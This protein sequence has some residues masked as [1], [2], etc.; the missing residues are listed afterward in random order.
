M[1]DRPEHPWDNIP[2]M[3]DI[4]KDR[5]WFCG[6][7]HMPMT[8]M[9]ERALIHYGFKWPLDSA[10]YEAFEMMMYYN[11][12]LD[13]SRVRWFTDE[14]KAHDAYWDELAEREDQRNYYMSGVYYGE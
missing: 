10:S 2:D 5:F 13:D 6:P 7:D 14:S 1:S 4:P 3:P 11:W 8:W 9:A 12:G